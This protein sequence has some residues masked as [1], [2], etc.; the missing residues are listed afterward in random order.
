MTTVCRED[1]TV[2]GTIEHKS[3][4]ELE[5]RIGYTFNDEII[6]KTALTRKMYLN[7]IED[8][9]SECMKPLATVGDAILGAAVVSW[10]YEKGT[11]DCGTLT[12]E[13]SRK[14]KREMTRDAAKKLGLEC[15]IVWGNG[16]E[17]NEIWN[18]GTKAFDTA[19]E[20]LIGAVFL[21]AKRG[22]GDGLVTVNQVLS[23]IQFFE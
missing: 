8:K 2:T 14:V 19:F 10:L 12:K 22:G 11:R 16:E 13:R 5:S 18:K 17:E 9:K 23:R 15:Y 6:L 3:P 7:E 4:K 20:A 21:D 1:W